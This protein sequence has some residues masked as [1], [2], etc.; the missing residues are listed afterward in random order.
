MQ[1]TRLILICHA[2]TSATREAR[3][4]ADDPLDA[5]GFSS[6]AQAGPIGADYASWTS[7]ALA[8]RQTAERFGLSAAVDVSLR[9]LDGGSWRSRSLA[10]IAD[11]DPASLAA[12]LSDPIARPHGGESIAML[13]ERISA[14][15]ESAGRA[16][17]RVAAVTHAAVIRAA[18]LHALGAPLTAFW[19]IDV[20][21]LTTVELSGFGTRWNL[22]SFTPPGAKADLRRRQAA[23][24]S[25]GSGG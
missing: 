9:D 22:R 20:P 16:A 4:G 23:P 10:E 18:I 5:H 14:W 25:P 2:S 24:P 17:N 8:A 3:F 15:L 19:R 6:I 11:A 7:P 12:W 13:A 21:P 1:A